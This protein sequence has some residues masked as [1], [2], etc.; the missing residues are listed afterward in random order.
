MFDLKL[1]P[2]RAH[3]GVLVIKFSGHRETAKGVITDLGKVEATTKL[4]MPSNASQLRSSLGAV[5]YNQKKNS[6]N[7]GCYPTSE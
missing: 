2:K 1:A 4:P 6:T 3:L 5:S 7:G